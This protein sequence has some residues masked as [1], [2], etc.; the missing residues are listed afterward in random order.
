MCHCVYNRFY[1]TIPSLFFSFFAVLEDLL[2]LEQQQREAQ[3]KLASARLTKEHRLQQQTALEN[4]LADLKYSNGEQRAQLLQAREFLSS[5]TRE[6]GSRRLEAERAGGDLRAFDRKLKK[7]LHSARMIVTCRRKIDS[8]IVAAR[9]KQSILLR[10]KSEVHEKLKDMGKK[11]DEAKRYEETL[12][13]SIQEQVTFAQKHAKVT[14]NLRTENK[15]LEQDLLAA[16]NM[17]Q[18]TKLRADAVEA[19]IKAEK[20]RHVT[21]INSLKARLLECQKLRQDLATQEKSLKRQ[22]EEKMSLLHETWNR[23]T[24][25]QEEEGHELSPPPTDP[26]AAPPIFDVVRLRRSLDTEDKHI[27]EQGVEQRALEES[28]D[29]LKAEFAQ[30]EKEAADVETKVSSFNES[31]QIEQKSEEERQDAMHTFLQELQ[32]EQQEVEKLHQ[33]Y[34]D[35]E[36]AR[37]QEASDTADELKAKQQA[38][39]SNRQALQKAAS[40]LD[41]EDAAAHELFTAWDAEKPVLCKKVEEA[42]QRANSAEK[43]LEGST[44]ELKLLEEGSDSEIF[45]E[46]EQAKI[47]TESRAA[48]ADEEIER[49]LNSKC[50]SLHCICVTLTSDS[51]TNHFSL[52]P[53]AEHPELQNVPFEFDG[54][55]TTDEQAE[56]NLEGLL[57]DCQVKLR[58]AKDI[59]KSKIEERNEAQ[60]SADAAV[61]AVKR[62]EEQRRRQREQRLQAEMQR[63]EEQR[64]AQEE[65]LQAERQAEAEETILNS[66]ENDEDRTSDTELPE[67]TRHRRRDHIQTKLSEQ[68]EHADSTS[69]QEIPPARKGRKSAD[70]YFPQSQDEEFEDETPAKPQTLLPVFSKA[71]RSSSPKH[72]SIATTP[73]SQ[74]KRVRWEDQDDDLDDG[75]SEPGIS[76]DSIFNSTERVQPSSSRTYGSSKRGIAAIT[77]RRKSSVRAIQTLDVTGAA[78]DH[79]DSFDTDKNPV[80]PASAQLDSNELN[81]RPGTESNTHDEFKSAP[82]SKAPVRTLRAASRGRSKRTYGQANSG[83]DLRPHKPFDLDLK[84]KRSIEPSKVGKSD[85]RSKERRSHSVREQTGKSDHERRRSSK[86]PVDDGGLDLYKLSEDTTDRHNDK[87]V[88]TEGAPIKSKPR[89]GSDSRTRLKDISNEKE[90]R[91][92]NDDQRRKKRVRSSNTEGQVS[93][94]SA[95]SNTSVDLF[96]AFSS[97]SGQVGELDLEPEI[98]KHRM[99]GVVTLGRS[100]CENQMKKTSMH[101]STSGEKNISD[102]KKASSSTSHLEKAT[103]GRNKSDSVSGAKSI[104][105]QKTSMAKSKSDRRISTSSGSKQKST[106]DRRS[107]GSVHPLNRSSTSVNSTSASSKVKSTSDRRSS[108]AAEP[109]RKSSSSVNFTSGSSKVESASDRR[110]SSSVNSIS[111]SSKVKSTSDRRSSSIVNSISGS[112]KVKPTSDRRSSSSVNSTLGSLKATSKGSRTSG[113]TKKRS[114]S[115]LSSTQTSGISSME[116]ASKARRRKKTTIDGS[117]KSGKSASDD[118]YDFHF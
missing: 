60:R 31:A 92:R 47:A 81:H 83:E 24:R 14:T 4:Q 71:S 74:D 29:D 18:S 82:K 58:A 35:L 102:R 10:L 111:G 99:E 80:T 25:Y 115:K 49:L 5:G 19:E 94:R 69:K 11:L 104:S 61:T 106:S 108:G 21:S 39:A 57:G 96:T 42:K 91:L 100:S 9:T 62:K 112:S 114:S 75:M 50:P 34:K 12:R 76:L 16:Q 27:H 45:E 3:R 95:S 48:E 33:S 6:L 78:N 65:C 90:G 20:N 56:A 51:V 110:S 23:I 15:C 105:D 103:S 84:P 28:S 55:K 40:E 41:S 63:K 53:P 118:P 13:K 98:K 73:L 43:A 86:G 79:L 36:Q 46:V 44:E 97:T 116:G 32:S 66:K 59:R 64:I 72:A 85:D 2:V 101:I 1:L 70:F 107:S 37:A 89:E 109:S 87:H 68:D 52:Y 88:S 67:E 30:L 8:V 117:K 17:E 26:Q 38:I 7:G 113:E 93:M 54:G 77:G 22:S